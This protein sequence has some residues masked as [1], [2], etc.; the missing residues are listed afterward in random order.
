MDYEII[1]LNKE[2]EDKLK[3][4]FDENNDDVQEEYFEIVNKIIDGLLLLRYN[5]FKGSDPLSS[6]IKINDFVLSH[7]NRIKQNNKEDVLE[8][9]IE[10]IC[11]FINM[12]YEGDKYKEI[13]RQI[14]TIYI[15]NNRSLPPEKTN[16]IYKSLLNEQRDMYVSKNRKELIKRIKENIPIT[17]KKKTL[18]MTMAKIK[19]LHIYF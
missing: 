19:I 15:E 11:Y 7:F 16:E 2:L 3:I 12:D 9:L 6:R 5:K 18:L 4:E 10:G 8:E 14:Y 1:K 13:V 17:E